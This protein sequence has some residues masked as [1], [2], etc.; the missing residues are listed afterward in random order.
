MILISFMK[1]FEQRIVEVTTELDILGMGGM[2]CEAEREYGGKIVNR[3]IQLSP[4]SLQN[5][6]A[7]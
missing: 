7:L 5:S 2:S 4:L 3:S 1:K 6:S